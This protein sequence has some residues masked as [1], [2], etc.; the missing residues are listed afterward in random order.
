[1]T[2]GTLVDSN[3]LLDILTEDPSWLNWSLDALA[4]AAES[5]PL[6]INPIIYAEVSIRFTRIE[7]VDVALPPQDY[8]RLDL[9]LAAAFLAGKAHRVLIDAPCSG[10]G[11]LRRN[12]DLKWRQ[13]P[14]SLAEILTVQARI[15]RQGSRCVAPG[16]RLVYATCSLLPEEN[17]RQVEGF[18][19]E[20]PDFT[21]VD[22][23]KLVLD[24]CE[25]LTLSGPFL[26]MRPDRHGTDGFFAAV[27]ERAKPVIPA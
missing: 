10:L 3:V 20:N 15:L 16:G 22:A 26:S 14:E 25:N 24:R 9:P 6:F 23:S 1:M 8:R 19:A 18:L 2:N 4:T 27:M 12:P 11:T 13:H 21:L 5:G 17:E 7:D